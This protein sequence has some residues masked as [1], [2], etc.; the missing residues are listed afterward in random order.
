MPRCVEY[1]WVSSAPSIR[2]GKSLKPETRTV[3]LEAP[4]L[5]HSAPKSDCGLN[6]HS[7]RIFTPRGVVD[8]EL[9]VEELLVEEVVL[10]TLVK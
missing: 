6:M 7:I 8:V 10:V 1:P 4:K 5:A 9:L 2:R 3:T